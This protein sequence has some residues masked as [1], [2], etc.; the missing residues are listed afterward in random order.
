MRFILNFFFFGILFYLIY[1]LFP[2]AF[3]T[4]VS[5]ADKAVELARELFNRLSEKFYGNSSH[6]IEGPKA[7][8]L[9]ICSLV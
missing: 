2:E 6:T 1:L 8:W 4:L 7:Y 3:H 5:W 9:A